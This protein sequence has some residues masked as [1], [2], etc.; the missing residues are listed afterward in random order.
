MTKFGHK[1][2]KIWSVCGTLL[3]LAKR[4]QP[5]LMVWIHQPVQGPKRDIWHSVHGEWL[6]LLSDMVQV[7]GRC[8]MKI[9]PTSTFDPKLLGLWISMNQYI[10]NGIAWGALHVHL[11]YQVWPLRSECCGRVATMKMV[12]AECMQIGTV[13]ERIRWLKGFNLLPWIICSII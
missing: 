2:N 5:P 3:P 8:C 4:T 9:R 13:G 10:I 7:L 6:S 1:Q 11:P 12:H